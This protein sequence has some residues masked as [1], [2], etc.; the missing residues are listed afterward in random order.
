MIANVFEVLAKQLD[1]YFRAAPPRTFHT[2]A[3]SPETTPVFGADNDPVVKIVSFLQQEDQHEFIKFPLNKVTPILI[4]VEEEGHLRPADRFSRV[5][6]NGKRE[7]VFPDVRL[8]L[9]MLL[10]SNFY[11]YTDALYYLGLIVKFFQTNPV[12][13]RKEIPEIDHA[14]DKLT[15][16]LIT[17][18][19]AEQNEVWNSLRSAYHPS[20]LYRVKMVVFQDE[21]LPSRTATEVKEIITKTNNLES[22]TYRREKKAEES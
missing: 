2:A 4:N 21:A 6:D 12:L 7:I 1:D 9:Y 19:F 8:N 17:L 18:P 14:I 15:I 11:D 3:N 22:Q 20:L 13:D 10:V 16:E 5:S